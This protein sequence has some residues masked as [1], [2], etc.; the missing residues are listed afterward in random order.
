MLLTVLLLFGFQAETIIAQPGRVALIAVPLLIQTY[1][2]FA[3]AYGLA[4][5]L[6]LPYTVVESIWDGFYGM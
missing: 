1:G 6:K 4:R 2:I 5:V 3:I